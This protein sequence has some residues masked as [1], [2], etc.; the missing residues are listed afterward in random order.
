MLFLNF[1]PLFFRISVNINFRH[2]LD[3]F[4][5]YWRNRLFIF[6]FYYTISAR[7]FNTEFTF[8]GMIFCVFNRQRSSFYS[9]YRRIGFFRLCNTILAVFVS[10]FW[11][12]PA[13]L[14]AISS[15]QAIGDFSATTTG[16]MDRMPT[17]EELSGGIIGY[18]VSNIVCAFFSGLPT[19]TYS[20]NVGIVSSTKVVA[21]RVFGIAAMIMLVAGI[22]CRPVSDIIHLFHPFHLVFCL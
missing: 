20:Q 8:K 15:I 16:G 5:C 18:G 2:S 22:I 1:N 17:D 14:F 4:I 6:L 3:S 13:V 7:F 10:A 21:K 19:A 9:A 12:K 11:K